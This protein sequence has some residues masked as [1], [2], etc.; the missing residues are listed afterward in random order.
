MQKLQ[1][2]LQYHLTEQVLFVVSDLCQAL[3]ACSSPTYTLQKM[4]KPFAQLHQQQF[5]LLCK[6]L[7]QQ[8]TEDAYAKLEPQLIS[9]CV[10]DAKPV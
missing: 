6:F 2:Q 10:R 1:P 8:M 3:L 9:C 4:L 7:R 5:G